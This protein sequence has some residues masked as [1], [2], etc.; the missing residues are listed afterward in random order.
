MAHAFIDSGFKA[1]AVAVVVCTVIMAPTCCS[2]SVCIYC[3]C[4]ET[5]RFYACRG[6]YGIYCY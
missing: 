6:I 1:A 5:C 2:H 3:C 4:A